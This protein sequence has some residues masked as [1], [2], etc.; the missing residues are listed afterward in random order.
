MPSVVVLRRQSVDQN[1]AAIE[2]LSQFVRIEQFGH[3]ESEAFDPVFC[4]HVDGR[5]GGET[6]I[7]RTCDCFVVIRLGDW[8]S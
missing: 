7:S 5:I 4:R 2:P 1:G 3:G 6:A 8:A